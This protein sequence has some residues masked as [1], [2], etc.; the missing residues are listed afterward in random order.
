MYICVYIYISLHVHCGQE[1]G[2]E[3]LES[4]DPKH[5]FHLI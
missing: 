3:W 2:V 4:Q 5:L 1:G